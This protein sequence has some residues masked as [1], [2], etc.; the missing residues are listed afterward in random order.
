MFAHTSSPPVYVIPALYVDPCNDWDVRLTGG[1]VVN[2]GRLEVC[3]HQS[4]GTVSDST[5]SNEEAQVVCRQ[6]GYSMKGNSVY[7][8]VYHRV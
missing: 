5:W 8:L 7:T 6:L 2:E 1:H 3:L 4:W